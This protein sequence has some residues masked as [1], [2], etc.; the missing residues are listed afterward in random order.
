MSYLESLQ[1]AGVPIVLRSSADVS[2]PAPLIILWHGFGVP[3]SEEMLAEVLPLETVQAWKAYLG[4]PLFG[5]R[6]PAGGME[7]ILRRQVDD[8]VLQLLLPSIEP[9]MQELPNVV[10]ALQAKLNIRAQSEI[11][12]FG[13]S[14]G[15]MGALLTLLES[16]LPI[17]AAVLSGVTKDLTSAVE[18]YERGMNQ[19]YPTLKAQFPWLEQNQ[20]PYQWSEDSI[21]ARYRLDFVA[22][23]AEIVQR[24][25]VP[26]LLFVHGRQ[27]EVFPLSNVEKLYTALALQYEAVNQRERLALHSFEHL[28]HQLDLEAARG[29]IGIQ[30]DLTE[31]QEMVAAW[32][33]QYLV[34]A[35]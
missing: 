31:L 10:Q 9:A 35:G 33:S 28:G 23:V 4:L 1:V 14:A 32:F 7:E 3:N 34:E 18:T 22:R 6:L 26:A 30:Q 21:T 11:G 8:Y 13:F 25:P 19:Y 12:L 15:G 29:S 27:D 17:K 5:Q 20:I 16:P 24:H 2:S